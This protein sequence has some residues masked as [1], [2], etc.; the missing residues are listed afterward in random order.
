MAKVDKASLREEFNVLKNNF[1]DLKARGQLSAEGQTLISSMM[2]LFEV[3]I[4]IFLEK[5]TRKTSRNS[6]LPPS[7]TGK[8]KTSKSTGSH[9]KGPAANDDMFPD[10]R[11][12]TTY[13]KAEVNF[14]THCS[15][16][17][18]KE[19]IIEQERRTKIDILFEKKVTHID[20]EV[21][22]C[23]SCK[24]RTKGWFP[25]DFQGP[26]Q[27]GDG[28]R[29]F[30]LNLLIGQL[31]P[32]KRVQRL[33]KTLIGKAISEATILKYMMQFSEDLAS[34]EK[35]QI[36][37]LMKSVSMNCDETSMKV[38]GQ[39][40]W[41]HVYSSGDTVLKFIHPKRGKEA[42]EDIGIIP[43][44]GGTIIHDCWASYLSYDNCDHAL[45]GSHLLRELTFIIDSNNYQ[46]A[47]NIK[48]LLKETSG[49]V[50]K[51][52]RKKLTKSAYQNLQKRYR[53]ILTRGEKELP[54]IPKKTNKRG[55]V[56]KSDAH[57]LWDRLKKYESSVLMFAKVDHV[58]FTNNR[59]EQDL[60]MNKVKQKISGSFRSE[61][62]AK[63]YCRIMSYLKTMRNKGME[64]MIS[65][66]KAL[67]GEVF[68]TL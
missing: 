6:S 24:G 5:S 20:A 26:I 65:I 21:K 38:N 13:E 60:R 33:I 2:I 18:S 22:D 23:P 39:N 16:D 56:A 25:T 48:K 68:K 41:V 12:V 44:Y 49:K 8:D 27:Y 30:I 10:V 67:K 4:S 14:C 54:E 31:I 66:H 11:T 17:I 64:P 61:S 57:N 37:F 32:L 42:I 9:G 40:Y 59:A 7:Q 47:K 53:N 36:E 1:E 43:K 58:P 45:C 29:V 51:S 62:S 63:A 46:W 28:L 35:Q 34:W 15:E 3:L 55:K 50:S 52:K 19:P